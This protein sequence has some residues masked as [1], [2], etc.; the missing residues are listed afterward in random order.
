MNINQCMHGFLS[1]TNF[2]FG[3]ISRLETSFTEENIVQNK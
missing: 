3:S 1:A 2:I